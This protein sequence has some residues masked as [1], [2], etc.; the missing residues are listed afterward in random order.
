MG[1]YQFW[2]LEDAIRDLYAWYEQHD[3]IDVEAL[4]F[5]ERAASRA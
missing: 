1:S 4:R 5:D 3:K 2:D